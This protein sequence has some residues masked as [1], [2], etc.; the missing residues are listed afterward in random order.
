MRIA[1]QIHL[2][3][4]SMLHIDPDRVGS[5]VRHE[6]EMSIADSVRHLI[7]WTRFQDQGEDVLQGHIY[8]G[9]NWQEILRDAP[10]M[11]LELELM[12]RAEAQK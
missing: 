4:I 12:R 2:D 7:C 8:A 10:T 5:I 9:S 1:R 11:M 6:I 3:S